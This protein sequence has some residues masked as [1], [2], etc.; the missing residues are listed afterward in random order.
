MVTPTNDQLEKAVDALSRLPHV[1][2]LSLHTLCLSDDD[3]AT[4]TPL[5]NTIE[6]L[7]INELFHGNLR[8]DRLDS[9]AD[10]NKLRSLSILST[11]LSETLNLEPLASLP[12]LTYL[13]IGTATL[14]EK[15]FTG[16][17]KMDSLQ[18][19]ELFGCRFNGEYL[20]RLWR[21]AATD[22]LGAPAL[23]ARHSALSQLGNRF[24]SPGNV[25]STLPQRI[26]FA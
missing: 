20:P 25:A 18:T 1:S 10:W 7:S 22:R 26:E 3:L 8:G 4:L 21:A 12:N 15:A 13:S 2:R 14:N 11:G 9:L 19:L 24:P 6:S 5:R 16:M 23:L 17:S